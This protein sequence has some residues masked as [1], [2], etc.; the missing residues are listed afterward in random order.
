MGKIEILCLPTPLNLTEQRKV[1]FICYG[2]IS[3]QSAKIFLVRVKNEQDYQSRFI[4][5]KA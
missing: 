1:F 4:L 2:Q 5:N 3:Y